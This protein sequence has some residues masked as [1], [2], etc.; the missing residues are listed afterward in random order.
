M[1]LPSCARGIELKSPGLPS[2]GTLPKGS[3]KLEEEAAA[4]YDSMSLSVSSDASTEAFTTMNMCAPPMAARRAA[5]GT[6][7]MLRRR[8]TYRGCR[9]AIAITSVVYTHYVAYSLPRSAM[10]AHGAHAI[11]ENLKSLVLAANIDR[12]PVFPIFCILAGVNDLNQNWPWRSVVKQVGMHALWFIPLFY[13]YF[14][15]GVMKLHQGMWSAEASFYGES[16]KAPY[17]RVATFPG[18]DGYYPSTGVKVLWWSFAIRR[19]AASRPCPEQSKPLASHPRLS[20][21][22]CGQLL[23]VARTACQDAPPSQVCS[24]RARSTLE[25][26]SVH[27][28]ASPGQTYPTRP[29]T[30]PHTAPVQMDSTRRVDPL[31]RAPLLGPDPKS[32]P[33][34]NPRALYCTA[35]VH[36]D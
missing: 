8:C 10:G 34:P 29:L 9:Y 15:L 18:I 28:R 32:P 5:F 20:R 7:P 30:C 6:T 33:E 14:P 21:S 19:V 2:L 22:L 25:L 3:E 24:P 35:Q 17:Q 1:P 13:T 16:A 11:D 23:E 27:A 26:A 12:V 36:R 4:E 31:S